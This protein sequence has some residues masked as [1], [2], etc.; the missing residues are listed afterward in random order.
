MHVA[1]SYWFNW[2]FGHRFYVGTILRV[3]DLNVR[4]PVNRK[5]AQMRSF[6]WEQVEVRNVSVPKQ[7]TH[8]NQI[9]DIKF[10]KPRDSNVHHI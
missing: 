6:L 10:G 8:F 1:E 2:F 4:N 7:N 5:I 9:E 3:L